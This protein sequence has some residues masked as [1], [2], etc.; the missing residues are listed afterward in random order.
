MHKQILIYISGILAVI[1]SCQNMQ[2]NS[3]FGS[4]AF[5][6]PDASDTLK[7]HWND[8]CGKIVFSVCKADS[9]T[10][11]YRID[12]RVFIANA[13]D[14]AQFI[15]DNLNYNSPYFG[16]LSPSMVEY[17][18]TRCN[19]IRRL[20]PFNISV[21]DM[22]TLIGFSGKSF[23]TSLV[24]RVLHADLKEEE[25]NIDAR[26][27]YFYSMDFNGDNEPDTVI[28]IKSASLWM[29]IFYFVNR[30]NGQYLVAD[31]IVRGNRNDDLEP[32]FIDKNSGLLAV[33]EFK[34]GS[35]YDGNDLLLYK[36]T[37]EGFKN[38]FYF[39][40]SEF[41][42]GM[43]NISRRIEAKYRLISADTIL[44]RYFCSMEYSPD[45]YFEKGLKPVKLISSYPY[46]VKY[47]RNP[48]SIEFIP[49]M[50]NDKAAGLYP[51]LCV[52][53]LDLLLKNQLDSLRLFG[54]AKQMEALE[55][56]DKWNE[57]LNLNYQ[58]YNMRSVAKQL[59]KKTS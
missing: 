35:G 39:N 28:Q 44:V 30:N 25:V 38:V 43:D 41:Q 49:A 47:F 13:K 5:R 18:K 6:F 54:S 51:Q 31:L 12:D 2:N 23:P 57:T 53:D 46:S 29:D 11:E 34:W 10:L 36:W 16:I 52:F 58:Q 50:K 42:F 55:S 22:K 15:S 45:S 9:A 26:K 56:S 7:F 14:T 32:P 33:K 20:E 37:S 4:F 48:D 19:D 8:S 24:N 40:E 27:L 59:I 3:A 17:L 1:L 21:E